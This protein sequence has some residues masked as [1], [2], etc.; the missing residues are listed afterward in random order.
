MKYR[1][2]CPLSP[3]EL[4]GLMAERIAF[5]RLEGDVLA[6]CHVRWKGSR[7]AIYRRE[8]ESR[9][10]KFGLRRSGYAWA[11]RG[12]AGLGAGWR[13]GG[14]TLWS[15]QYDDPFIGEVFPGKAGGSVLEGRFL[16]HPGCFALEALVSAVC[17]G[18]VFY[19]SFAWFERLLAAV[20]AVRWLYGA[21]RVRESQ[22]LLARLRESFTE[23]KE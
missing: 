15:R 22:E 21:F 12:S 2:T 3:V 7:F 18:L 8:T 6:E 11:E 14:G 19:P 23:E 5:Y 13:V 1:F 17:L 9:K 20:I 10:R 16:P 4:P